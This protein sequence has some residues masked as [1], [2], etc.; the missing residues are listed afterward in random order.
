MRNL[1]VVALGANPHMEEYHIDYS[2]FQIKQ[3]KLPTC[4]ER[5]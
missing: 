3:V 1:I 5:M 2:Q 4:T